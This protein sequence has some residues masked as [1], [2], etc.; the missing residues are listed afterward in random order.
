MEA[1]RKVV[2]KRLTTKLE[3]R[4]QLTSQVLGRVMDLNQEGFMLLAK[5]EMSPNQRYDMVLNL[6]EGAN[7]SQSIRLVGECRW[8]QPSNTAGYYGAG[9]FVTKVDIIECDDWIKLVE[10]F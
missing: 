4:D 10:E 8:C 3:M 1:D 9:F 7:P 5:Q 6:Q 2:R